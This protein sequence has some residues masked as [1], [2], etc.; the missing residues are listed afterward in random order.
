LISLIMLSSRVVVNFF[1][2]IPIS[3]ALLASICQTKGKQFL[4]HRI[5]VYTEKRYPGSVC[6]FAVFVTHTPWLTIYPIDFI[7]N[8][9]HK[10]LGIE[11][12]G[13]K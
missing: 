5:Y 1:L 11:D 8:F 3:N 13:C 9:F 12:A 2:P 4:Y 6:H 7:G 10:D